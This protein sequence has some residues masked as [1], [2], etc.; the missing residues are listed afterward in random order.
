MGYPKACTNV[1]LLGTFPACFFES[2]QRRGAA[3]Q[4]SI[5]KA[6]SNKNMDTIICRVKPRWQAWYICI[7]GKNAI[8]LA[9]N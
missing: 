4:V 5:L 2:D 7:G 1:P 9:G 8:L 3:R 6:P